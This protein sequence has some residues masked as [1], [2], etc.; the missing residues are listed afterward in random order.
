MLARYFTP[1]LFFILFHAA[2]DA[3]E[4][5][6]VF[7]DYYNQANSSNE[8][9]S[10]FPINNSGA[11]LTNGT[12]LP[13]GDN[14]Y[15]GST[16]G[17]NGQIYV[18]GISGGETTARLFFRSS[19][20]WQN[21]KINENGN[22][23][24]L[25]IIVDGSL[26]ITGS[27]TLINAIIYV[28]GALTVNNGTFNGALASVG[29]A[30]GSASFNYDES[31]IN[32][33][34]FNGMC[35]GKDKPLAEYR[36][37]ETS[38]D[39]SSDEVIDS[40]GGFHGQAF[41]TQPVL[42]KVCNAA[43]FSA[44]GTAD[45]IK[46]NESVLHAKTDFT[47]SVWAKTTKTNNQIIL[48]GAGSDSA[49]ELMFWFVNNNLFRPFLRGQNTDIATSTIADDNWHH[50]VWT[51][52]G[53]QNCLYKD[54][55]L[56]GCKTLQSTTLNIQSLILGQEQDRIGGG[57][58]PN[59]GWEG[60]ID[61][62][63]VFDS[64][65]S[66]DEIEEIYNNQNAGLGYDG[67][68]RTCPVLPDADPIANFHFDECSYSGVNGDT[69]D[70]TG[71]YSATSQ[72][73]LESLTTG[74]VESAAD[75]SHYSHHFTTSIPVPSSFSVSTWFKKPTSTTNSR[76]FV[77]GA[78]QGGGDLLYLDRNNSWRWGVYDGS[79]ST[80][81]SY[82]FSS[83][84]DNWH[85]MVLNYSGS[86]TD[87]YIDGVLVDTIARKPSGTLAYIGTSY[88]S[89]GSS[90]AQGFRAPLDEFMVFD[91]ALSTSQ[92]ATIYNNQLAENNYDGTTRDAINCSLDPIALY[93]FEQT[94]FSSGIVDSS[95]FDNHASN[96]NG[97]SIAAGKYC[98]AFDSNGTN[99]TSTT[100][101]AFISSLDLDDDVGIK[102][103]IS[104]WFNSN[105]AWD[106]GGY[107]GGER[108]LFDASVGSSAS[109]K[110]FALE[111]QSSGRLRFTFEDSVDSDFSIEEP[112]VGA[113]SANTWYYVTV[114]WDYESDTFELYV[115]GSLRT[116]QSQ[117]TNGSMSNLGSIVFGDNA[118]TYS[119]NGNGS[120]PSRTSANGKFDEVR[121]YPRVLSQTEISADM[122][123][124]NGCVNNI[125]HYQI[126]HDGQ[127]L[128][129]APETITIKACINVFDGSCTLS[130]DEVTLDVVATG[131][132][133]VT[134]NITFTGS[135]TTNIAY[136]TPETVVL[137]INNPTIAPVSATVCNDNSAGSCDLDFA[138]AGFVFLNGGNAN[139]IIDNQ[140]SGDI[141]NTLEIQA[142]YSNN[143]VCEGLFTGN[144]DVNLSQE[145]KT[146]NNTN[147]GN[148]FEVNGVP[149]VKGSTPSSSVTLN[150][151]NDSIAT[152]PAPRYL[153]AG[154]IQLHASY[155]EAGVSLLGSSL[156]FW[157]RPSYFQ[158]DAVSCK[159]DVGGCNKDSTTTHKAGDNFAFSVTA[160]NSADTITQNYRQSDGQ[161]QLKL[162]RVLPNVAGSVEGIFTY[163]SGQSRSTAS[164]IFS[165]AILEDFYAGTYGISTF[166]NGQYDEVGVINV[167]VEDINYGGENLVI[168]AQDID[169]GRFTPH[170][171]RQTIKAGHAGNLIANHGATCDSENWVYSGQTTAGIGSIRYDSLRP[172]LT[173]TAYNAGN[174]PTENYRGGFVKLAN[175]D[176]TFGVVNSTHANALP[177]TGVV[178]MD[179][180]ITDSIDNTAIDK[181]SVEYELS[182]D[183]HFTYTRNST[184]LVAPFDASFEIP[185]LTIED[186]DSI[187]LKPSAGGTDYFVNP[188]F[189]LA[190]S[191]TV[192]VRFGRW[193]IDNA[194]GPETENL[195]VTMT[196][197]QW[198]GTSFETNSDESCLIP[199]Y[200]S[201]V[202]S[203]SFYD[204]LVD[205]QYRLLDT[206]DGEPITPNNTSVITPVP[207]ISFE[208]GEYKS[209]IFNAPDEPADD[210]N[211]QRGSL[212]FEYAVPAWLKYDWQNQDGTFDDNPIGQITFG[213][214]R[215]NDRIIS[216][217]EVEN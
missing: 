210:E 36:F 173:I 22:P 74:V 5:L 128:T 67:S 181:G 216:W 98:R 151:G 117:N 169:I 166:A 24:D 65:I 165:H 79:S 101:N 155:N 129:C 86:K 89:V 138:D 180:N 18:G 44:Y 99:S 208:N 14:Y 90:S 10:N 72:N 81:G 73:T 69:I 217:R 13:R 191:N 163:A 50:L 176:V 154:Q 106:Q 124:N 204:P 118:S 157:V 19:V 113:R 185:V 164:G 198:N 16:V 120:L 30:S 59:Q 159:D 60:L 47:V 49:N 126:I 201:K 141:F 40:I 39:S 137:S 97:L 35:E 27:N 194:Y 15:L 100:D 197:Q 170:H 23:E 82:S 111:L 46:L 3:S 140:V 136:T 193:H 178:T 171:Y 160:Y 53:T 145:N 78:M 28:K 202:T 207:L 142:L 179:G 172:T 91:V 110:Y 108:T 121:I 71:S 33:A 96:S 167:D 175:D 75:I 84:D 54:N 6:S 112:S 215:G 92:I 127:G 48:S 188:S 200:G 2:V 131:A 85:H 63:V 119:A 104:F 147:P 213:L 76:Y 42:G 9:L 34:D 158:I 182:E 38:Y 143:G 134:N 88:D 41:A 190:Q 184:S 51:R 203:G 214:F 26:S 153:D 31:F 43:D 8:Q 17:N 102:G 21:V 205:W 109:D 7:P 87:L 144:V 135:T 77:L 55:A 183:H 199:Q 132:P 186:G 25:I 152:I 116:Q 107:N 64:A 105:T 149:I 114:T 1:L 168:A 12:T 11:Y 37:D 189:S 187:N 94:D 192:N 123:D 66:T 195:P 93:R 95:G 32:N 61:E 83:L 45:Y 56:Q 148:S 209:F 161:L 70:Q 133:A 29:S 62:L 125:N 150:F 115:D 206:P 156:P 162:T 52:S 58:D 122:D 174:N 177:L 146:P 57:F 4:C 68:A 20:S 211:Y 80:N 130:T 139:N 196:A 103:T 212:Q